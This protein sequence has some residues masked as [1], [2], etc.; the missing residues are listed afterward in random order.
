LPS[1][2]KAEAERP[3]DLPV[4][5]PTRFEPVTN[6]KTAKALSLVAPQSLLASAEV[7]E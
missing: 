2:Q 7:I 6:L 5:Q 3:A 1:I 4:A